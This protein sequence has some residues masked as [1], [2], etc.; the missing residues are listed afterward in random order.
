MQTGIVGLCVVGTK[1]GLITLVKL[2]SYNS[3]IVFNDYMETSM[4]GNIIPIPTSLIGSLNEGYA[5]SF[6]SSC[7]NDSLKVFNFYYNIV[8]GDCIIN[9]FRSFNSSWLFF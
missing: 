5:V 7:K 2:S 9:I 4:I 3:Y 1:T 6:V 8:D